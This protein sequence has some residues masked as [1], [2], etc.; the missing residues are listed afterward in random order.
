MW[1]GSNEIHD[2]NTFMQGMISCANVFFEEDEKPVLV[3]EGFNEYV[4]AYYG[5]HMNFKSFTFVEYLEKVQ[6][7]HIAKWFELLDSYLISLGYEPIQKI[8]Q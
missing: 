4:E 2:L 6:T 7:D 1:I 3:P 8:D 5:K